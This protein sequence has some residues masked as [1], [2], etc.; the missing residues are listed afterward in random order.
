MI[1]VHIGKL[2][3]A[4]ELLLSQRTRGGILNDVSVLAVAFDKR[5]SVGKIGIS[6][7]NCKAFGIFGGIL[8]HFVVGRKHNRPFNSVNV[9]GLVNGARNVGDFGNVKS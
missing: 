5:L 3:N 2:V 6:V 8:L 4:V 9:T 7:L 1:R